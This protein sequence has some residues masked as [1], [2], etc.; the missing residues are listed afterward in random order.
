M[1]RWAGRPPRR[2]RGDGDLWL[3]LNPVTVNTGVTKLVNGRR[4]ITLLTV[5]EHSHLA[6]DAVTYR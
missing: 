3:R 5:N 4:G 2:S 1:A 6:P